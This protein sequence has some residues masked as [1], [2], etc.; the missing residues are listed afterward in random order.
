MFYKWL[1][2]LQLARVRCILSSPSPCTV[3][4]RH[5]QHRQQGIPVER[6]PLLKS[7][8]SSRAATAH[9]LKQT[10]CASH[11]RAKTQKPLLHSGL[12]DMTCTQRCAHPTC[13]ASPPGAAAAWGRARARPPQSR[14]R[15]CC[16]GWPPLPGDCHLP[17]LAQHARERAGLP[18]QGPRPTPPRL[19]R[20]QRQVVRRYVFPRS[21]A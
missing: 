14:R 2:S 12:S 10:F 8:I 15:R 9:I 3:Q 1:D 21:T 4:Q 7:T 6:N 18:L 5:R 17:P 11:M 16:G 20:K 19:Q 13:Q